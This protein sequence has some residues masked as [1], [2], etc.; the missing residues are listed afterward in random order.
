MYVVNDKHVYNHPR[1]VNNCNRLCPFKHRHLYFL[2]Y[3][4][5]VKMF[6]LYLFV[7]IF[8]VWFDNYVG[9]NQ[10]INFRNNNCLIYILRIDKFIFL[11]I[12]YLLNII[13]KFATIIAISILINYYN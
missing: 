10:T 7:F 2:P 11:L 12:L 1:D 8:I 9:N 5:K 6:V 13:A 3:G 4:L